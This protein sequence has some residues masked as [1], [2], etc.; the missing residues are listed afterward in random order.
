MNRLN[1]KPCIIRF[2]LLI[3][4]VF[5]S[6]CGGGGD[7]THPSQF[8]PT[9]APT[10][11]IKYNAEN[12]VEVNWLPTENA[13]AYRVY[14]STDREFSAE[15]TQSIDV[16]DA[17]A[18]LPE[19]ASGTI[20]YI[21]VSGLWNNQE[22]PRAEI[23][24]YRLPPDNVDITPP[25]TTADPIGGFYNLAQSIELT[26]V[27]QGCAGTF[28]TVDGENPTASSPYSNPISINAPGVTVLKFFSVDNLGNIEMIKSETYTIDSKPPVSSA[29]LES[30][31]FRSAQSVVLTCS[32]EFGCNS[33]FYTTDG[34]NPTLA[35][36]RYNAPI[37]IATEGT[38]ELKFFSMDN[39][40][41]VEI[42]VSKTYFIDTT[43]PI[44]LASID[45]GIYKVSQTVVL[46]CDDA[47]G[48]AGTYYTLDG[49]TPTDKS[50][51]YTSS[52][53]I[54]T[55]GTTVLKFFSIDNAGNV[56][57]VKVQ[58]YIIDTLRPTTSA[59][60]LGAK[61][62][63]PQ[64]VTLTCNDEIGCA[65]IRYTINGDIPTSL[66]ALYSGPILIAT[67]GETELRFFSFDNAGNDSVEQTETYLIDASAPE[68]T[69]S[70]TSGTYTFFPQVTLDCIGASGCTGTFYTIDGSNPSESSIRYV[71]PIVIDAEGETVLKFF[72]VSDA[73]VYE[74]VK[75]E[76]YLIDTQLPKTMATPGGGTYGSFPSVKLTCEDE[77]GCADTYYTTDDSEP[78]LASA[79]YKDPILIATE[80]VTNL[81]FF[82]V[83]NA[84][85]PELVKT[86]AY[87][88]DTILPITSV[89]PEEGIYTE[90]QTVTL[91][92]NEAPGCTT[93]YTI[94][95]STPTTGS[96]TKNPV[97]IKKEGT[98]NLQFFSIDDVGH[99]E[100][101]I[102]KSYVIDTMPPVTTVSLAGGFYTSLQLA[103]VTLN[104]TDASSGCANTYYTLNGDNPDT[105]SLLYSTEI[106]LSENTTLKFF[107]VDKAGNSE[108]AI[109]ET[110]V[111]ITSHVTQI[112]AGDGYTIALK[113]DRTVWA[114]GINDF[115][116]L[117]NGKIE[118]KIYSS[119]APVCVDL[120]C[121]AF[122]DDIIALEAGEFHAVALKANG[123]V[124]A[125]GKNAKGQL[126][127]GTTDDSAIPVQVCADEACASPLVDVIAL[128]A[129]GEH[130]VVLKNDF[131][132]WAWGGNFDG[133]LGDGTRVDRLI[134][135]WVC[136][137][138]SC[139]TA[140]TLSNA[141]SIA[142]GLYHSVV[143]DSGNVW[144][145]G[146]N[147]D[148][149]LGDG[150]TD[151]R[152]IP[153]QTCLTAGCDAYL[154]G[155]TELSAG[156]YHTVALKDDGTVWAWGSNLFGQI[157]NNTETD[158]PLPTQVCIDNTC[159][160]FLSGITALATSVLHTI[161]LSDN[162]TLWAWSWNFYG[163]LG[164]G[165]TNDRLMAVPVC[166]SL[167]C[168]SYMS[169][170]EAIAAGF[171]H[172]VAL[173]KDGTVWTWGANNAGQLGY[174]PLVQ[175]AI[176]KMI[177]IF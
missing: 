17:I 66:S 50:T 28:F 127:N 177:P 100:T 143:L 104:C 34:S 131:S 52:I 15:N 114:W 112:S 74:K 111:I 47:S 147:E 157:G 154:G 98:T 139:V 136:A 87:T 163:Q 162:G 117:G 151:N 99:R 132:V 174:A 64:L 7:L 138:I 77:Q 168:D 89:D 120:D 12:L 96:L 54:D 24:E 46:T 27:D 149:Q 65:G 11:K 152:V 57:S 3:F 102:S 148:G 42:I 113:Q 58:T 110:Y 153:V 70:I 78:T 169:D 144:A 170:I 124:W 118:E 129:G 55:E 68:T 26:C 22:S 167:G 126:G 141:D 10:F 19:I 29:S 166:A 49:G 62:A 175:R 101:M 37:L 18:V 106:S 82:S 95:G 45:S 80:G 88:I 150:T 71:N 56:T 115:G 133:Q 128:A 146:W 59:N 21:S 30:G 159:D 81:K 43:L 142:A 155:I 134:P 60:P 1:A 125:W 72:S 35:S 75:T 137:N 161:A 38:T 93:Y 122:L 145:W 20:I 39:A 61:Y 83:D 25:T 67:A 4:A 69:A 73:G 85:N 31:T 91:T 33:I 32:D 165:S 86:Q 97:E 130:V 23:I 79:S 107:S 14:W 160:V 76:T 2:G 103:A 36:A 173:K 140:L 121:T 63:S 164:D 94:D 172:T 119:P 158:S 8:A 123:T 92:C 48:C 176:P 84:G 5:L 16:I 90:A 40:G 44:T 13:N 6:A 108:S 116:Q 51:L 135:V 109:I 105:S 53:L 171:D 41:N 156:F 9:T